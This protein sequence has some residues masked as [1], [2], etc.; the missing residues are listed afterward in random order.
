MSLS[1]RSREVELERQ[2][3]LLETR[4]TDVL[5]STAVTASTATMAAGSSRS[6]PLPLSKSSSFI[7][8]GKNVPLDPQ[9]VI[10]SI[11]TK[12]VYIEK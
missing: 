10:V 3:K 1:S 6:T 2:V 5:E 4:L 12:I 9:V 7:L 8:G 11:I